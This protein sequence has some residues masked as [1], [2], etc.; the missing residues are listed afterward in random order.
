MHY[1]TINVGVRMSSNLVF[2]QISTIYVVTS[3]KIIE[4]NN[5]IESGRDQS[6]SNVLSRTDR[7]CTAS[8]SLQISAI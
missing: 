6:H 4:T 1:T 5:D 3:S 2:D 8:N 7:L